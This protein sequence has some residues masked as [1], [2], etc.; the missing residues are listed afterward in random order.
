MMKKG[1]LIALLMIFLGVLITVGGLV[2][3]YSGA[4]KISIGPA[5]I[6]SS[7]AKLLVI[8]GAIVLI[9]EKRR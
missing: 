9:L 1:I 2:D 8:I 4:L 3:V 7:V 6:L 5:L